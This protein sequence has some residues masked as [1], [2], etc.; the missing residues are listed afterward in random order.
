MKKVLKRIGIGVLVILV[1]LIATPFLFQSQIKDMIKNFINDNV[2]AKV[3]FADVNLSLLKN[4]P[5]ATVTIDDLSVVNFAPFENDTLVYSKSFVLEMSVKELFKSSD[6]AIAVNAITI[7]QTSINIIVDENGNANYDIAKSSEPSTETEA[8]SSGFAFNLEDYSI[9]NSN[10]SYSD[11]S[12]KL[13][14]SLT[15]FN[16]YGQGTFSEEQSDLDTKTETLVSLKMDSTQYLNQ[17]SIKLDAV[18]GLHLK[19][20]K[21]TFKDN[22]AFINQLPLE[23][24]GFIQLLEEGQLYDLTFKN[25][26]SSFKD[27]LAL[28][29][30]TYLSNLNGIEAD[31]YF[32]VIGMVEG[33]MTN[34]KLPNIEIEFNS[35]NSSFKFPDLPKKVENIQIAAK[36]GNMFQQF[37]GLGIY[38]PHLSFSIDED[39]FKA[40][41]TMSNLTENMLVDAHIDG[42]LNLA[43]ISKAYPITLENEL[44]GILKG[45]LDTSF[46]M[47]AIETNAYERIKN[48]G[49]VNISDFVFSSKDIV[50]PLNISNANIDFKT[51][52]IKLTAFNATSGTSDIAATGTL[53]NLLG[54]LLSNK[55]LQGNFNVNSNQFAV[56]DFMVESEESSTETTSENQTLKIPAFLDCTVNA[57]AKTVLYDNLT[58]NNVKGTL[59]LKDE[60]AE[61]KN[62]KSD[63]FDGNIAMNGVV[64]T[65]QEVP[66]FN[67]NL[68][69]SGL[70]ISKSFKDLDL[71]KAIVPV[72][73]ALQGKLN[74]NINLSG[75]LDASYSPNLNTVS[76][77]ALAEL[78][79]TKIEPKNTLLF[80]ALDAN[81]PFLDLNKLNLKD[82]KTK[83]SFEN[84]QVAVKPF[85]LKYEDITIRVSGTHGF[86]KTVNY[87]TVFDVP[88]KYLGN[89]VTSL[90]S[91]IDAKEAKDITVPVTANIGGSFTKPTITTDINQSVTNLTN[92]LIAIKKKQL[93]N[94]GGNLLNDLLNNNSKP[95]DSTNTNNN[96]GEVINGVL[97][98][99]FGKKKK[100]KDSTKN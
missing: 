11:K 51:E 42:V 55:T 96:T 43:N 76:G 75:T 36:F 22:K 27:F 40:S 21:Y 83:L 82:L 49:T 41:S 33:L 35:Q 99:L 37:E 5:Q 73:E 80:D 8:S 78:L 81:I 56:S 60:K 77:D 15:D 20:N 31:G 87:S 14:F 29:P 66:T 64:N 19:D 44:S 47:N 98:N 68:D 90:L 18:I 67:M 17:H 7:D 59:I 32:N 30:E 63:I 62:L 38:M 79:T 97:G 93:L 4:F 2:N 28:V 53:E 70:D 86:D 58:L 10:I 89:E 54:F 95:K 52:S 94:Q 9:T 39:H 92:Q 24:D 74:S 25:P 65:Q 34:D 26:E 88:A 57:N 45:K 1:L 48:H 69:A 84:G 23:F 85:D 13:L 46:D 6:E 12:S 3:E 91:Q 16:H 72:A 71:L 61:F 50:N 100:K